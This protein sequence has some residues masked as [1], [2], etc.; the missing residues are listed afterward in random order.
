MKRV[1]LAALVLLAGIGGWIGYSKMN[2]APVDMAL[3]AEIEAI[4]DAF[5]SDVRSLDFPASSP[6]E[7]IIESTPAMMTYGDEGLTAP[8]W[9]TLPAEV[10][11]QMNNWANSADGTFTGRQYFEKTFN[12]FLVV[13]ELGHYVQDVNGTGDQLSHYEREFQAN[14]IAVAYWKRNHRSELDDYIAWVRAVLPVIS[15][16]ESTTPEYY[17]ANLYSGTNDNDFNGY[18]QFYFILTAYDQIDDLNLADL[19]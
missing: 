13:H 3:K 1:T 14:Q 8:D 11:T 10:V 4:R 15:A 16:P 6:P 2:K 17:N 5:I 19:L 12:W 7:V 18:F 9:D